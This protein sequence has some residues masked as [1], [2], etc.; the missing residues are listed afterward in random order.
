M[1]KWSLGIFTVAL[2]AAISWLVSYYLSSALQK[3]PKVVLV[4]FTPDTI[5]EKHLNSETK[6]VLYNEGEVTAEDCQVILRDGTGRGEVRS[7]Q[8]FGIRPKGE[9]EATV[10]GHFFTSHGTHRAR[11]SVKCKNYTMPEVTR[12]FLVLPD[13][14]DVLREPQESQQ[15][16]GPPGFR[17]IPKE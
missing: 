6:V 7:Q 4:N 1:G 16:Q 2:G 8:P 5:A 11:V 12:E 14:R 17:V 10:S 13:L 15:Q 9:Y 3:H